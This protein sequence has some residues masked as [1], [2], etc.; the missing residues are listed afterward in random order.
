MLD[1]VRAI[2]AYTTG[3]NLASFVADRKTVGLRGT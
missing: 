2:K 1:A 3:M